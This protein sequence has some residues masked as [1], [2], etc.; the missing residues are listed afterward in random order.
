M[1]ASNLNDNIQHF[2]DRSTQL[3]LDVWGE[4]M[5]HGYYGAR[6]KER[7]DHRQAQID[8]V[9]EL[10]HWGKVETAERILDV[11]CGVGGSS[12]L[13]ASIFGAEVLGLTLS[14]MQAKHAIEQTRQ[15]K[16][17][18]RV[19]FRAQDMMTLSETDG[20]FDLIWS[21]ESAEHINDKRRMLEIFHDRLQVGGKLLMVTW[22]HRD[23]PPALTKREERTLSSI[24]KLYHLPPMISVKE[25][26]ELA[27]D[28]G[29][30]N[31]QTTDWSTAVRPFWDAVIRSAFTWQS[32][33]GLLRSGW[34]TIKGAYAMR[35]MQEG[36]RRGVLKYGVIQGQKS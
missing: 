34:S 17:A 20:Q 19:R 18:D 5:H 1:P 15:C 9:E 24:R 22:C 12:R 29:F 25:Y 35:Y 10:L 6:G 28:V 14:P 4:H 27:A 31:V 8:L 2:Y 33:T 36:F 13:L 21:L 11:G 7:K 30:I 16:L 32:V 3:W 26:Q 23:T